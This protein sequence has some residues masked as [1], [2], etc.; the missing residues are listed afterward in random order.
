MNRGSSTSDLMILLAAGVLVWALAG[1]SA[2]DDLF[3]SNR[4]SG[5]GLDL[6][7][8]LRSAASYVGTE[9]RD[10]RK[11]AR[12]L[13]SRRDAPAQAA[14]APPLPRSAAAPPP[15]P[16]SAPPLPVSAKPP[17]V[18]AP[19]PPVSAPSPPQRPTSPQLDDL[20]ER[21]EQELRSARFEA[22]FET[23]AAADGLIE[24][25]PASSEVLRRRARLEVLRATAQ[26]AHGRWDAARS[27]LE[28]A[29]RADPQLELDPRRTSPKVL[30]LF[31]LV[32]RPI[33]AG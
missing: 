2:F 5:P 29:V 4:S 31:Q 9:V 15:L 22:A 18:S 28:R 1:S 25:L 33:P 19:P 8:P 7:A 12:R 20:L 16:V 21:A 3:R 23:L 17:P 24:P 26:I 14:V 6:V 27:S 13:V 30:R 32:Q 10:L 11:A